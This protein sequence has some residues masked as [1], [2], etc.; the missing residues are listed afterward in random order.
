MT[1]IHQAAHA[2]PEH[3]V[4]SFGFLYFRY[5]K[6]GDDIDSAART[7]V[8]ES[9]ERR[10]SR[11]DQEVFIA[12]V[13]INPFYRVAPFNNISLTTRAGLAALFT[14]LWLRFYGGDVP[15]ELLT[16]LERYLDSSGDFAYMDL[17][18]NS[19]LARADITVSGTPFSCVLSLILIF[20]CQRTP[21]DALDVWSASSHPGSEPR[22]LH[23][24]ARR[25]LS[26]CP[27]SASCERLFSVFGGILTKWR[28]RLS[29]ENLTRL[30]ELKM[31]V[32]EEHVRDDAV[33][34]RLKRKYA[35]VVEETA[36][37]TSNQAQ[38]SQT[39]AQQTSHTPSHGGNA[40]ATSERQEDPASEGTISTIGTGGQGIRQVAQTLIQAVEE[41]D[42]EFENSAAETP[43]LLMS[44]FRIWRIPP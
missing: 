17:Y 41:E 20:L 12:A 29:T 37:G 2:R 6:L 21:V 5:S 22:P 1:N 8:L 14:R 43:D 4:I 36:P 15:V 42:Q 16:D 11:C 40:S 3:V 27:N 13:I 39:A 24:I 33:K 9:A 7:A 25:L 10:W 30:A 44:H 31:Y 32:H 23:K 38:A 26:I 19:L 18:K 35:D 34:K 28:N